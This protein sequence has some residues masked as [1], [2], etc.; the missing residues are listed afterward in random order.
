[1]DMTVKVVGDRSS[2][3]L[4]LSGL[5]L[6]H[7]SP[8][9]FPLH[10]HLFFFWSMLSSRTFSLEVPLPRL[11]FHG[12]SIWPAH[13]YPEDLPSKP[14]L[15]TLSKITSAPRCYYVNLFI[16]FIVFITMQTYLNY[17]FDCL[18]ILYSPPAS[19]NWNGSSVKGWTFDVLFTYLEQSLV[20]SRC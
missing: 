5:I 18:F 10:C 11:P 4:Y 6:V 12:S 15:A 3:C 7:N 9:C 17:V 14:F 2:P 8:Q 19:L 1:M 16:S 13:S 20:H